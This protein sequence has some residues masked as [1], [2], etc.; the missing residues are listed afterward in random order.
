MNYYNSVPSTA[1]KDRLPAQRW[2]TVDY[3]RNGRLGWG[4]IYQLQPWTLEYSGGLAVLLPPANVS[5]QPPK[6][7]N[8]PATSLDSIPSTTFCRIHQLR[9]VNIVECSV[10][11]FRRQRLVFR[12]ISWIA[13]TRTALHCTAH[14]GHGRESAASI[15]MPFGG[16]LR[17]LPQLLTCTS[18]SNKSFVNDLLTASVVTVWLCVSDAFYRSSDSLFPLLLTARQVLSR[19]LSTAVIVDTTLGASPVTRRKDIGS[20]RS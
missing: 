16:Y 7:V 1:E 4:S 17:Y 11:R 19:D 2:A 14:D 3:Y 9:H 8:E 6:Q 20:A 12:G 15:R 5:I 10:Q 13:L 18:N